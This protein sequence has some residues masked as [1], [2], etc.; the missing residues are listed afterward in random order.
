M[1]WD[2]APADVKAFLEPTDEAARRRFLTWLDKELWGVVMGKGGLAEAVNPSAALEARMVEAN[3]GPLCPPVRVFVEENGLGDEGLMLL[4]AQKRA[5]LRTVLS[6]GNVKTAADPLKVLKYR[7]DK[8]ISDTQMKNRSSTESALRKQNLE[9]LVQEIS[10]PYMPWAYAVPT[11]PARADPGVP[12]PLEQCSFVTPTR[13]VPPA[14][15]KRKLPVASFEIISDDSEGEGSNTPPHTVA[16][17]KV[18]TEVTREPL[19]TD[20]HAALCKVAIE[21]FIERMNH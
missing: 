17:K 8:A 11:S 13:I 20:C 4:L 19:I 12:L 1:E 15:L 21:C 6:L 7:I 2:D 18:K 3:K 10:A 14:P 16:H 5:V 9:H